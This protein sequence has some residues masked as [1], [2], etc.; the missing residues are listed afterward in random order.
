MTADMKRL[1]DE[2]STSRLRDADKWHL[3][4][5][6]KTAQ[7]L[8]EVR[9]RSR[10]AHAHETHWARWLSVLSTRVNDA[11]VWLLVRLFSTNAQARVAFL[12][13][14]SN[15]QTTHVQSR[16]ND[17]FTQAIEHREKTQ[18]V[19]KLIDENQFINSIL[20]D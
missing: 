16:W 6:I 1:S 3:E 7:S 15:K 8:D 9:K 12:H 11:I 14:Q 20:S 13:E 5:E 18:D 2:R 4:Q 17:E 19:D 10:H